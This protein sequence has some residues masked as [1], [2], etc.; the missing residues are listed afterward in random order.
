MLALTGAE[1]LRVWEQVHLS[2]PIQRGLAMLAAAL[3]DWPADRLA[4]LSIGRRDALLLRLREQTFGS[5]LAC[6]VN[7][8]D[9]GEALEL[10]LPVASLL[11]PET[12]TVPDAYHTRSDGWQI[13]FRLPNSLDLLEI[14]AQ[15]H[16]GNDAAHLRNALL[17]RCLLAVTASD[18]V[19]DRP[20]ADQLPPEITTQ[21]LHEMEDADPQAMIH[22]PLTC[23]ACQAVWEARFDVVSFL[24]VEVQAH[25]RRLL[26]EVH[27]LALAYGWSE[28]DILAMSAQ[29]RQI[30]LEMLSG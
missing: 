16:Q 12:S 4:S 17:E 27:L 5:Q 1:L 6:L 28:V 22:F 21:V 25:A 3:P 10:A 11:L 13:D 7:C 9:C 8:P 19:L 23:P 24:W 29:R 15:V 2:G 14:T 20:L 18:R 30:Y 26:Q